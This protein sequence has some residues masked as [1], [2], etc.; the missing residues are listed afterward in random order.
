[1]HEGTHAGESSTG[2]MP[3][4][5]DTAPQHSNGGIFAVQPPLPPPHRG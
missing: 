5:H 3:Q 2:N 4:S 1:V